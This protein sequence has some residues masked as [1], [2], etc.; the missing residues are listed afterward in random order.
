MDNHEILKKAFSNQL[1]MEQMIVENNLWLRK[2]AC[3][4]MIWEAS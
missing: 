3:M 4:Q 1:T 2:W